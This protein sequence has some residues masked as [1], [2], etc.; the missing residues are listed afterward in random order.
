LA[1]DPGVSLPVQF[2][3]QNLDF[4]KLRTIIPKFL[5]EAK[6]DKT[7][8]NVDVNLKFTNRKLTSL[9]T[10]LKPREFGLTITDIAVCCR[11]HTADAGWHIS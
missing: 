6:D 2:V 3:I 5:E 8:Q 11:M 4:E 1:W 9:S 10:G 7:F